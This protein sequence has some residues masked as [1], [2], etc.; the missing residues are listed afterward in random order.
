MS[1][2]FEALI[3]RIAAA[4]PHA[5]RV[6]RSTFEWRDDIA[7]VTVDEGSPSRYVVTRS[8]SNG[9]G[10]VQ[11]GTVSCHTEEAVIDAVTGWLR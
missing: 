9:R 8:H 11:D 2:E 5:Q 10:I 7:R 1:T 4:A 6:G 3:D